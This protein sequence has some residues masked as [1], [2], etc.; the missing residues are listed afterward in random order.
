MK[1]TPNA[2]ILLVEDDE[3]DVFLMKR[4]MKGTQIANPLQIAT[5]GQE[6]LDY[7]MGTG[8]FTDR[9][10]F[11]LPSLVF[12]DLKLPY[13]NGFEVLQGI[14]NEPSLNSII[15][16]VLTSSSEERDIQK[17]YGLGTH[18]FL[19]KPP[20]PQMLLELMQSLKDYWMKHNEFTTPPGQLPS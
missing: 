15:V 3:N 1:I 9:S 13:K 18:S 4:A 16:V 12:L 11:P 6:A 20:T 5:N 2:T 7:M 10:Q 14:R 8:K 17:A 19:I